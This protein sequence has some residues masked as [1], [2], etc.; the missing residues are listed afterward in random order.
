MS[1][2]IPE[3]AQWNALARDATKQ[4]VL[5]GASL[6]AGLTGLSRMA[7]AYG[8]RFKRRRLNPKRIPRGRKW[9][10]GLAALRRRKRYTSG[11]GVTTQHDRAMIYRKR[12]MPSRTKRRWKGFARKVKWIDESKLGTRTVVFNTSDSDT[13]TSA[14]QH[15][16]FG[17]GLYTQSST[18]KTY[19]NDLDYIANLENTGNPTAVADATIDSTTKFMFHSA[20]M[21]VTFRNTSYIANDTTNL[22]GTLEVDVYE[23]SVG[24][25]GRDSV[26]GVYITLESFFTVGAG[27]TQTIGGAIGQDVTIVKRG[28]TP[29]DLPTALSQSRVKIYKK[30]KYFLP[31]G[32][33][34]TY[35]V[36]DPR[37]HVSN[38]KN[39]EES[40]GCNKRGWT[41]W[42]M[43]VY[44]VVPGFTVGPGAGQ[45]TESLSYGL[46]RKYM[47]KLEG[48]NQTRDYHEAR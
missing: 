39:M 1:F 18:A 43:I 31:S 41:R 12:N 46:T 34:F 36:R 20:V 6:S 16:V 13:N 9:N 15:G 24:A 48:F 3:G 35:Q 30:S 23:M 22:G 33:T 42:I 37:R 29:W 7:Y 27:D 17:L 32:G 14:Q 19:L 11:K 5:A 25:Y 8:P 44:K 26:N 10:R 40:E 4:R 21:D 45:V 47:Y 2:F 28:V 38:Y